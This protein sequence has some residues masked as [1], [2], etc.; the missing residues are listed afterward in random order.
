[1]LLKYRINTRLDIMGK[2]NYSWPKEIFNGL[3]LA[4]I[5]LAYILTL[6]SF[7]FSGHLQPY[8]IIGTINGLLATVVLT[9]IQHF[10]KGPPEVIYPIQDMPTAILSI[11]I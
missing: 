10:R 11:T 8:L 3:V 9:L 7:L 2:V 6:S 4:F 5:I 1:M